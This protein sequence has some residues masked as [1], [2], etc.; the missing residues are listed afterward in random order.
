MNF[1]KPLWLLLETEN[2]TKYESELSGFYCNDIVIPGSVAIAAL[3][4][5][6][7]SDDRELPNVFYGKDTLLKFLQVNFFEFQLMTG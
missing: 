4:S 2:M 1:L 7:Q 6:S 3:G 5:S